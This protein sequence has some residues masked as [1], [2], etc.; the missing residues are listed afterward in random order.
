M[1]LAVKQ[2]EPAN[3]CDVGLFGV[4]AVVP[5]AQLSA[6]TVEQARRLGRIRASMAG[7]RPRKLNDGGALV[8]ISVVVAHGRRQCEVRAGVT[9]FRRLTSC[10]LGAQKRP[11]DY[12]GLF[13]VAKTGFARRSR[14]AGGLRSCGRN[15]A[16]G[17]GPDKVPLSPLIVAGSTA[18]G[19]AVCQRQASPTLANEAMSESSNCRAGVRC[20]FERSTFG[21]SHSPLGPDSR[22]G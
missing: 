2:D 4:R 6:D 5:G 21:R 20:C 17:R 14:C 11:W 13:A 18:R 8:G 3:P 16:S 15:P 19:L 12:Q 9:S 1:A 10:C 7:I 22:A